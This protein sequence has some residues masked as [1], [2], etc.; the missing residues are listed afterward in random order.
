MDVVRKLKVGGS[1]AQFTEIAEIIHGEV[2]IPVISIIAANNSKSASAV[3]A[4]MTTGHRVF[5]QATAW[6]ATNESVVF[7][8]M[9]GITGG[10]QVTCTNPSASAIT[11]TAQG[12]NFFAI[13]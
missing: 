1:G 6:A 5:A 12:F 3:V 11:T 4:G 7:S 8:A 13:K 2:T 9:K 10:V